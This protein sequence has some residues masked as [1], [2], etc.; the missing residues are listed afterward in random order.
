[1]TW[2]EWWLW[3]ESNPELRVLHIASEAE[4]HG[5]VS[6]GFKDRF[7]D[8]YFSC[9]V[10][11]ALLGRGFDALWIDVPMMATESQWLRDQVVCRLVPGIRNCW[12]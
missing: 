3:L 7:G 9:R 4:I 5:G 12:T 6:Q 11:Q 8:Q 2:Q 1:M 10:G